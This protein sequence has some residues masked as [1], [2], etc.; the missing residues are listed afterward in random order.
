LANKTCQSDHQNHIKWINDDIVYLKTF[1]NKR[2]VFV[3]NFFKK[4]L[5]K[6]WKKS[7]NNGEDQKFDQKKNMRQG[8]FSINAISGILRP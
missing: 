8:D 2:K 3:K 4:N 7:K 5:K 1:V 6:T